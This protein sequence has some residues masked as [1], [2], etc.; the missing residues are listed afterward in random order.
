MEYLTVRAAARTLGV[1]E[2]TIRNWCD[3]GVIHGVVRLPGSGYRRVQAAE[4]DRLLKE[5][6]A[7]ERGDHDIP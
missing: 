6:R 3:T 7:T 2:N 5:F 4:V 1:H